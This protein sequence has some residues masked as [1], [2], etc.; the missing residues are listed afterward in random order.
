MSLPRRLTL[1]FLL[2]TALA[3]LSARPAAGSEAS[4]PISAADLP[5]ALASAPDGATVTVRGGAYHGSLR[6]ERPVTLI[7]V[8]W[9]VID[10][11]NTGTVVQIMAPGVTLR[12]FVIRGS[13][14]SLD[15]ENAGIAVEAPRTIVEGNRLEETLF[16]IYLRQADGSVIQGNQITSKDLDVQRRGDPIRVWYSSDV[17][18]A[19]NVITRGRDVVLWYSE[20]LTVRGN[21]VSEGRY[22]LHF[23]YCDDALIEGNRLLNNSVGAFL[24]YSR[25]MD[26]RHN[27]IASNR[28]P[29]GYGVGLK[30]MDDAVATNNL[31]LDNRVGA[32]L[33][34]SPRE[35][36]SIGRFEG[37]VFAYNDIGVE[38][39]PAVRNNAF[40]GNSF[41]ENEEQMAIAGSG[42]PGVNTW[43]IGDRGNYWS[44]YAGYDGDADGRGDVEY[45]SQRLF[46]D[47]T[48]RVPALKLFRYSPATDALDFAARAFPIVRPQPRLVD[49]GPLLA[50]I[51]PEAPA[52]PA[53]RAGGWLAV[54]A[55]L[56]SGALALAWLPRRRRTPGAGAARQPV[57]ADPAPP[58]TSDTPMIEAIHLTKRYG[59]MLALDDLSFSVRPGEAVAFWGANGAGKT[60]ALR[61]LL[62]LIPFE[63]QITVNGLDVVR[64][65]KAVRRLIGLV[66]QELTFHDDL[67]VRQTLVFYAALRRAQSDDHFAGLLDRLELAPHA[68]KRVRDLSGGL[69]QRLALALALL[70]DPPLLLLDEPTANLDI[71]A[72]EE[73]LLLLLSLKRAGKTLIFSSH[74]LEEVTALADRVLLL[75]AGRLVVDAPPAELEARLG[76]QTTLHLY[77]PHAGIER[78]TTALRAHGLDV[79]PNGRGLRVQLAPGQKG[80]ALRILHDAGVTV[81]D[82]V[83]E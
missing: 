22:G 76:W 35:V 30:D 79:S 16:G 55:G 82:F 71:R 78:A 33:D 20:R 51:M 52:L 72:R 39:L 23:M 8:D 29:S 73:F 14:D 64:Q 5:A 17:L 49:S 18:I 57:P 11:G 1:F 21:D 53:P 70:S 28:G 47:L 10:G 59:Q 74:R 54:G 7:G 68:G 25:R 13:G 61:C 58:G 63:G 38:M 62:H 66:P 60:T 81:D 31:F 43:T 67:T 83:V 2:A 3:L 75:E 6:L 42:R 12:G 50:P 41:V 40:T 44:D 24:M 15:E 77:L 46:E 65:G 19:D 36:D 32:Y 9:P 80:R 48:A 69:K 27:T 26:L 56:V 34:G 4:A 37:N 45:R